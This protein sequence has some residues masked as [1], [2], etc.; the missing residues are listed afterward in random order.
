MTTDVDGAICIANIGPKQRRLRMIGGVASLV[1]AA[2]GLVLLE[3]FDLSRAS[4]LVLIVPLWTAALA[5]LQA[6][7]KT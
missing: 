2:V 4:R 5:V 6:R 7:E 3:R 1:I